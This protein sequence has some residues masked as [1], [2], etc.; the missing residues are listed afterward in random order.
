MPATTFP[1][2]YVRFLQRMDALRTAGVLL[3]LDRVRQALKLLGSPEKG[4]DFVQIAGTNGKGST[5]AMLES[6]LR[7]AGLRTALFTSPHLLRFTERLKF[8]GVE[9]DSA[10]LDAALDRVLATGVPLTY[11]EAATLVSV[12]L[13]ADRGVDVAVMETGLGGRL[14]AVTALPAIVTAITSV[15]ADHLEILGPTLLDVAREKASIARA[16]VPLFMSPLPRELEDVVQDV[17]FAAATPTSVVSM[18]IRGSALAGEH[19]QM[20]AALALELARFVMG[21]QGRVLP[22]RAVDEGLAKVFWPGRLEMVDG[23]LFDC[24]H[25]PQGALALAR[26]LN[27]RNERPLV[28]LLSMVSGKDAAGFAAALFPVV[29]HVVLTQCSSDRALPVKGLAAQL[30]PHGSITEMAD[31]VFA[32]A[33]AQR[34]AHPGGLVV[35]A[36]SIFLV[37]QL[38][39]HMLQHVADPVPTSDPPTSTASVE[40]AKPWI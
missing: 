36:G 2:S 20:N 39:A 9:V 6:V 10:L 1:A 23:V 18:P 7:A 16:G 17:A 31:P 29:Q 11:F 15:G 26:E 24:A 12:C 32:L 22:S 37:G 8:D 40:N 21:A 28:L 5:C 13:I 30:P 33:A 35:V 14:D 25:N 34:S 4:I 19:Q 3:G 38:R 27:K